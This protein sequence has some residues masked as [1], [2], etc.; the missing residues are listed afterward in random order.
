MLL[1]LIYPRFCLVCD[2][3]LT[4]TSRR[5][6][7]VACL[8]TLTPPHRDPCPV[9]AGRLG[10]GAAPSSCR[11]CIRLRPRF[12]ACCPVGRYDGLLAELVR[13]L[14]Y[15]RRAELAWPAGQL[16]AET[17]ELDDAVA[18]TDLVVPVPIPWL[19]RLRRGFNQAEL[20]AGE[21][22]RRLS[23]PLAR[24]AL[25]RTKAA[26]VQ[27]GLARSRRLVAPR[28]TMRARKSVKDRSVLLVDD[29][30]T[31][32]ATAN[33]AARALREAGARRVVVA[34]VARA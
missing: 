16:L 3:D 5:W 23:L 21:A 1:D 14:K 18:G 7:C 9:C 34:V 15:G 29:V 24:W 20:I 10:P 32:G 33:E 31:T 25:V 19:R 22:A 17:L 6:L 11:D 28:G 4:K 2:A 8:A 26:P 27:A 30:M 13:G 12:D